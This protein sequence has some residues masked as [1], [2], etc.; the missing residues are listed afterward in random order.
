MNCS[1]QGLP[2]PALRWT[3]VR[4][5]GV[6]EP[7]E[8]APF[9]PPH[10]HTRPASPSS[11]CQ[12]SVPLG[13]GPTLSLSSITFDTA[14]T[15]ICEASMPTVPLLSRTQSF[16]LLVQGS[17]WGRSGWGQWGGAPG[18]MAGPSACYSSFPP[19]ASP[20]PMYLL[21]FLPHHLQGHLN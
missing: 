1:V 8:L 12:D 19:P 18:Q 20:S 3:K 6:P 13:T 14:G 11:P 4:R 2:T 9:P 10:P 16:R 7:L 21:L 5:K 15:Y 17:G